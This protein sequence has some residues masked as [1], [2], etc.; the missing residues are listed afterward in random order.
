TGASQLGIGIA[1]ARIAEA[2]LRDERAVM[3]IGSYQPKYG[4][5]LSLPSVLGRQGVTRVLEPEMSDEESKALERS[6]E[7]LRN[8]LARIKS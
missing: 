8:A 7:T 4:I 6:A 2:I 5:T 1:S 3:P